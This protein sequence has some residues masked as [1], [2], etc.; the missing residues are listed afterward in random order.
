[1][2]DQEPK[3]IL[4]VAA[5]L[6]VQDRKVLA[7]QRGYGDYRGWWEFPGGKIE[8]GETPENALRREI[9]EELST[10]I[11]ILELFATVEYEYE[12]FHVR[13]ICFLCEI[14]SD[15]FVL[16]EHLAAKWL[17]RDEIYSVKWLGADFPVIEKMIAKGII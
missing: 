13:L 1:M 3:P 10:D 5:A 16:Q 4:D 14:T 8:N 7:T 9:G 12:K 2:V 17:G 15:E 11:K 6:V